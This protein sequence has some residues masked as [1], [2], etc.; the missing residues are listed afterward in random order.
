MGYG[1][2]MIAVICLGK[3]FDVLNWLIPLPP[4]PGQEKK[5]NKE[6]QITLYTKEIEICE[7]LAGRS[8]DSIWHLKEMSGAWESDI[9]MG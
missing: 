6:G 8:R 1:F 7:F 4:D 2:F 5:W 9:W 3:C